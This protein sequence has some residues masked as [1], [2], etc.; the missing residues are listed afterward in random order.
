MA[1]IQ[2][3]IEEAKDIQQIVTQTIT[4]QS[5]ED[6]KPNIAARSYRKEQSDGIYTMVEEFLLDQGKY[7]YS[8]DGTVS[9][10][11]LESHHMFSLVGP[12]ARN[13]WATWKRN[14]M[15]DSLSKANSGS[16]GNYWTPET[17]GV[18]DANFAKFYA[19]YSQGIESYYCARV[20]TKMTALE[21]DP[22]DL[23]LLGMIDGKGNDAK[24]KLPSNVTFIL[25]SAHG[26]MEGDK[27]RNT[28]EYL[29]SNP[30]SA[31][32]WNTEIYSATT[33]PSES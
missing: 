23:T 6:I 31:E 14:P 9:S 19:L 12:W 5:I 32:G 27:W 13:N 26:Q 10:E 11:P 17:D 1:A 25:S 33:P 24:L 7:Q 21:D 18:K 29:G 15:A 8:V 22:P 3:K 2:T 30:Q 28:Y 20:V 4:Q 16:D